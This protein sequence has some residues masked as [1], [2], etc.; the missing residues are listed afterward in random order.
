MRVLIFAAI[1]TAIILFN[2]NGLQFHETIMT[3][4]MGDL[5]STTNAEYAKDLVQASGDIVY[6]R[7]VNLDE[8]TTNLSSKFKLASIK[9]TAI[10]NSL[11]IMSSDESSITEDLSSL[12]S[13]RYM[14]AMKSPDGLFHEISINEASEI[15]SDSN[16]TY[17]NQQ[18]TTN[19][20]VL[21]SGKL[22][23]RVYDGTHAI[24]NGDVLSI[25]STSLSGSGF[26]INSGLTEVVLM[27]SDTNI[28]S[29]S[30]EMVEMSAEKSVQEPR[31]PLKNITDAAGIPSL[32]LGLPN[33]IQE[34]EILETKAA[35]P[36]SD[37]GNVDINVSGQLPDMTTPVVFKGQATHD[38][39]MNTAS[40]DIVLP[41][42]VQL[43]ECSIPGTICE[44]YTH[45][46]AI[47]RPG[48]GQPRLTPTIGAGYVT[49]R[50]P[51]EA[52]Q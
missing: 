27:G 45:I 19:Y 47:R 23:E 2:V 15:E 7:M 37:V 29:D 39:S 43:A 8:E 33:A 24:K 52:L 41:N 6:T 28:L 22:N 14:I 4:G 48:I 12:R 44:N 3:N 21:A 34:D 35:E 5:Y 30:V 46:F 36:T 38:S 51:V 11:K 13:N 16:I 40:D 17:E 1:W 32:N 20:D 49:I 31:T 50:R 9:T 25:A 10:D 18:V 26:T 42:F